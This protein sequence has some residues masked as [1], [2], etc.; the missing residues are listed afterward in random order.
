MTILQVNLRR[1]HKFLISGALF[2][3]CMARITTCVMRIVWSTRPTN[4]RIGIAATVFVYAGVVLLFVINLIF[5][6]RIIRATHPRAGWNPLF[7]KIFI[8]L[9]IFIAVTLIMLIVTVIQSF[10]TL[11]HNTKR[12][13]RDIN[14]YAQTYYCII[15]FLP[16]PL[17]IITLVIPHKTRVEKFGSG[18]IRTKIIILL[19]S[20][21]L[22]TL[23][24]AFRT[25]TSYRTPRP[26]NDP[27]WYQS[28]AC[29]YIFN[30][31]IEYIVVLLYVI[32]RVDMRFHVPNGS[33]GPG[34]YSGQQL[35]EAEVNGDGA[36]GQP[37]IMTEEEVFDDAP[38]D[39]LSNKN[40]IPLEDRPRQD[41][42][43]GK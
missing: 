4:I 22:L 14:L 2:G 31:T 7:S 6:Q 18:R 5:A 3:F 42:E 29:F 36:N 30:L 40:S 12:I 39:D 13:D 26:R 38:G 15:A 35:K 33:K 27:A 37:R 23:G 11:N 1:G 9:Y 32:V 34:Y 8:A 25:G 16:I 17:I 10:Y 41:V 20:S 28:K 21:T 19:I 24:A 43:R